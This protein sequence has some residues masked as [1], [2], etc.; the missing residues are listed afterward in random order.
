M[1]DSGQRVCAENVA[2]PGATRAQGQSATIDATTPLP[3]G[4]FFFCSQPDPRTPHGLGR[5][6]ACAPWSVETLRMRKANDVVGHKLAGK[7]AQTVFGATWPLLHEAVREQIAL[8]A[9]LTAGEGE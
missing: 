6:Y 8:H 2:A 4:W 5:W 3:T 7:L 9:E 1:P